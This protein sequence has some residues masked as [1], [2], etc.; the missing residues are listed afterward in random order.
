[1]RKIG[2]FIF[3]IITINLILLIN[4]CKSQW[5]QQNTGTT[6][7]L[8]SI[9]FINNNTGWTCGGG[10]ILKTTNSG[11]NWN[12][13][14]LPVDKN[15][16]R[17]F[18]IDSNNIYCVGDFETIIKSTNGGSNWQIIRNGVFASNS[19]LCCYFINQ[20][21]GWI[22]GGGERKILKTTNGCATFDSIVTYTSGFIQD[23]YFRDTLNG[24]YCDDNGAV[25][26]TTNGGLNWFSIN[27]Q[28]GTYSYNYRNFS[29]INN[30][31]GWLVT[32]SRKL[33]KTTDFGYNW[34]SISNI[35]NGSYGIHCV[36]FSSQNTG[37]AGGEGYGSMFKSIDG[38]F[39]WQEEYIPNPSGGT[40]SIVFIN[41]SIGWK[42]G[43]LGRIYHTETSGQIT[44][45]SND[46]GKIIGNI[47]LYQNYPNP[48]N[49]ITTI[50]FNISETGF[51]N[52]E[53]FDI[54]GRKLEEVFTKKLNFGSYKVSFNAEK[55][56]SGT[57]F[58]RL[59]SNKFYKVKALTL[60]K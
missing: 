15:L 38:G 6:M 37:W 17:I 2:L 52:L 44:Q 36:F 21:T 40:H 25:R 4:I 54:L 31:T 51:Y 60:I 1:M 23:I 57:Y 46:N 7:D 30:Q 53:V 22:S 12:L 9:K 28:S 26:K 59:S 41:D 11:S 5:I 49:T 19:Y 32:D 14:N 16:R 29:I 3:G 20:N 48:F 27:I 39:N 58:Y 55:L 50:Q 43:N 42:A 8:F 18:P 24:L 13:L 35:P 45:I 56:N 47:E 34:D 33:F 10:G